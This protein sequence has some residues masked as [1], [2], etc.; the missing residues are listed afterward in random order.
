MLPKKNKKDKK[1]LQ[2]TGVSKSVAHAVVAV[3]S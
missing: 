1:V 3:N 2:P